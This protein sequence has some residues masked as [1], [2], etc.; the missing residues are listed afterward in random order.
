MIYLITGLPGHGKTLYSIKLLLD[1]QKSNRPI[2]SDID[3]LKIPGVLESPDDWTNTPEGSVVSYDEAQKRF[4]ADGSVGRSKRPDIAKMEV[5]RH[6]GHDL[7]I[8]TQNPKLIHSHVRRLVGRHHHVQ[9]Q[10][11]MQYSRVFT[12]D[13]CMNIESKTD[14]KNADSITWT[15]PKEHFLLYESASQ[16]INTRRIE[17]K[18]K[19]MVATMAVLIILLGYFFIS[20]LSFFTGGAIASEDIQINKQSSS[21]QRIDH[22]LNWEDRDW[23]N[24]P[25]MAE[26]SGC[27]STLTKCKCFNNEGNPIIM[28]TTECMLRVKEPLPYNIKPEFDEP[29]KTVEDGSGEFTSHPVPTVDPVASTRRVSIVPM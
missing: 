9:R 1:F 8:I 5:H 11:G 18:V 23:T 3:G 12:N 10:M 25:A 28:K 20:S 19:W 2:Y 15:F 6:T 27:I 29:E 7:I 22:D 16:H 26:V 17:S 14:L 21:I 4:P 13:G 24:A